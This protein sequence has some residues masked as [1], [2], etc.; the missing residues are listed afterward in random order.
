MKVRWMA[1]WALVSAV[2]LNCILPTQSQVVHAEDME[3]A[4]AVLSDTVPSA[5]PDHVKVNLFNYSFNS[6][7]LAVPFDGDNG[8]SK[9]AN[10]GIN[11]G[12]SLAFGA[13][14]KPSVSTAFTTSVRNFDD[15]NGWHGGQIARRFVGLNLGE[16]GYPRIFVQTDDGPQESSL[17]YLFNPE[18]QSDSMESWENVKGL[19]QF[20]ESGNYYYDS[21]ENFAVFNPTSAEQGEKS[22]G[23][24]TLY[25]GYAVS[26]SGKFLGEFF[27]FNT[28][29]QVFEKSGDEFSH[30][31]DGTLVPANIGATDGR[32]KHFFGL[33][34]EVPFSQPMSGTVGSDDQGQ[35]IPMQFQFSGDDDVW[36]YIDDVLVGDLGGIHDPFGVKIDFSTGAVTYQDANGNNLPADSD[37]RKPT[38]LRA[39]YATALNIDNNPTEEEQQKFNRLFYSSQEVDANSDAYQTFRNYTSHTMKFFYMERGGAASNLRL[40]FNLQPPKAHRIR[41]VNAEGN[42]IGTEDDPA[43][44]NL[45]SAD[46]NWQKNN[47][48]PIGTFSSDNDGRCLFLDNTTGLPIDF[49][50]LGNYFLLEET[51]APGVYKTGKEEYQLRYNSATD[52][53]IVNNRYET[54]AYS[55]FEAIMT[56]N[57]ERVSPAV[58]QGDGK[59]TSHTAE[60]ISSDDQQSGLTVLVP[61]IQ[62]NIAGSENTP[63]WYPVYG[64]NT[65][66]FSILGNSLTEN[67]EAN[68]ETTQSNI[69]LAAQTALKQMES[70]SKDSS[71]PTWYMEWD[72]HTNRLSGDI[73]NLPGNANNYNLYS[74]PGTG[75]DEHAQ[76]L[77]YSL[78]YFPESYLRTVLG[79]DYSTTLSKEQIYKALGQNAA[80]A[81]VS[82]TADSGIQFLNPAQFTTRFLSVLYIPNMTRSLQVLKQD[83]SGNP[84][85]GAEFEL[86]LRTVPAAGE[87]ERLVSVAKGTT[88][89]D[90]TLM[91]SAEPEKNDNGTIKEGWAQVSAY[92]PSGATTYSS[93]WNVDGSRYVLKE[94]KAPDG[95]ALNEKAAQG[96]DAIQGYYAIYAD[97]GDEDDGVKVRSQIGNI[98]QT[99]KKYASTGM[100]NNTLSEI[101]V[102]KQTQ[103]SIADNNTNSVVDSAFL[104]NWGPDFQNVSTSN[105]QHTIQ[106]P[107]NLPQAEPVYDEQ[108]KAYRS[109]G[110]YADLTYNNDSGK[111][112]YGPTDTNS[113]AQLFFETDTGYIRSN[114]MQNW[115]KLHDESPDVYHDYVNTPLRPLFRRDNTVV[116]QDPHA[117]GNLQFSVFVKDGTVLQSTQKTNALNSTVFNM[118]LEVSG[119]GLD[120]IATDKDYQLITGDSAAES[121]ISAQADEDTNASK[122]IAIRFT[123]STDKTKKTAAF[124]I[125]GTDAGILDKDSKVLRQETVWRFAQDLP[126]G[127]HYVYMAAPKST[128]N[129][130]SLYRYRQQSLPVL[131]DSSQTPSGSST[132]GMIFEG[133]AFSVSGTLAADAILRNDAYYQ[134][135]TTPDDPDT[136]DNPDTPDR[137][138]R[139][140]NPNNPGSSDFTPVKSA[141]PASQTTLAPGQVV[142]YTITWKNTGSNNASLQI[143]D[144]LDS[145]LDYVSGSATV[146]DST[147]KELT[148]GDWKQSNVGQT[149][150]WTILNQSAGSTGS[151]SFQAKVKADQTDKTITNSAQQIVGT[152]VTTSNT[153][154]HPVK[155]PDQSRLTLNAE[156][157]TLVNPTS[158]SSFD[159]ASSSEQRIKT[160]DT[161]RYYI[162]VTNTGNQDLSN[163]KI[164]DQIPVKAVEGDLSA[165]LSLVKDSAGFEASHRPA[166]S[167]SSSSS[168]QVEWTIPTLKAG[169]DVIVYFDVKVPTT[170]KT[171][172]WSNKASVTADSL[173]TIQTN[174][175]LVTNGPVAGSSAPTAAHTSF[176][177]WMAITALSGAAAAG[178]MISAQNKDKKL[179]KKHQ[180]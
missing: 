92:L 90:G 113:S 71:Y 48:N 23:N 176:G 99:M 140:D 34:M 161:V 119:D 17:D 172:R 87:E 24:F 88:G 15:I 160:G 177:S 84:V 97:A 96:I 178:L 73:Y 157:R 124:A 41:K 91:F 112:D 54:G 105:T 109:T 59:F 3:D 12:H 135:E 18:D 79:D 67:Q 47:Q 78:L 80:A 175:V 165:Q 145:A 123:A 122:P 148:S 167:K 70:Y 32:L 7:S 163:V 19:F 152:Q 162:R 52:Q 137:P 169:E 2:V 75:D 53:L 8:D 146:K 110:S 56:N 103:P 89:N 129:R 106:L 166:S 83:E 136:P 159:K 108:A 126:A 115:N 81:T 128:P 5:N 118:T 10:S 86:L 58:Y 114:A 28:A 82:L 141:N 150:T 30:N 66:G 155:N 45:Y 65:E 33:T 149:Y 107:A 173:T 39:A 57:A 14:M 132:F 104:E 16:D 62:S 35:A 138:D 127:L 143:I 144:R 100:V 156:K 93:G 46:E 51:K 130:Y 60:S 76:H 31:S 180:K 131:T 69:R 121:E 101:T 171:T 43:V 13:G 11:Q 168:T 139:P 95:F 27:P 68:P 26:L 21:K 40:E 179:K 151:V 77:A 50:Q 116:V 20:S 117:Q 134:P 174:E 102:L 6:L 147:G 153:V 61:L 1:L 36:I 49:A 158:S 72:S 64:S 94:T 154:S 164:T 142:T 63:S 37:K 111:Y 25:N 125:S 133:E 4:P 42:L 38:T 120:E 85:E 170:S 22:E 44:F 98:L 55:S 74:G 29:D 9:Y